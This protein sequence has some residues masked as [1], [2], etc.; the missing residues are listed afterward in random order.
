MPIKKASRTINAPVDKVF[1]A[2]AHIENFSK[3]VPHIIKVEHLTEA[4]AGAG[5]RFRET[6]LMNG[7]EATT[8]LEITEYRPNER[9]RLVSD[10]GGT[11]W[12]TVF[13]I[14]P[15][16]GGTTLTMEM[17]ARPHKFMAKLTTPLIMGLVG[18]AVEAD[19]D[20]VK[21]YCERG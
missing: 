11:I 15:G 8:E 2:V 1:N 19:M 17:I 6:R 10:A 20:A 21:A 14:R 4:K 18:K 12:D 9:V 16:D 13:E 5:A 7:R 3:A